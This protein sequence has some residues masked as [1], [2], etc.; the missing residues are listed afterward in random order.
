MKTI[1]T[2]MAILA[3]LTATAGGLS[4]PISERPTARP[5]ISTPAFVT[6][7]AGAYAG[8]SFGRTEAR[9]QGSE[10]YQEEYEE[11]VTDVCRFDGG[12]SGGRK[13]TFPVG[14]GQSL[15]PDAPR[16]H[17]NYS[18]TCFMSE[19][20]VFIKGATGTSYEYETGETTTVYGPEVTRYF[21]DLV[22]EGD[23]GGF[24]GYRWDITPSVVGGA[25]VSATD[26][27]LTGE[28]HVGFPVGDILPYVAIGIGQFDGASGTV[29]SA[30]ADLRVTER[31]FIGGKFS[32]GE[33]GDVE[34]E[35]VSVRVGWSF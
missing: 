24:A 4:E 21:T 19:N 14:V 32:V 26:D 29:Y 34:T 11:P 15:F 28:V 33:F 35:T 30:G 16:C 8:L 31:A 6:G 3:P 25:E 23:V 1:I 9:T 18:Q 2:A 17:G 10:T 7:W 27:M 22:E 13:C 12:H 20:R 5:Q